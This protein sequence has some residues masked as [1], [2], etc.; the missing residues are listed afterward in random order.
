MMKLASIFQ[1]HAVLQRNV[2]IP[3]WGDAEPGHNIKAELA[4]VTAYTKVNG[5]GSFLL[6]FPVMSAGGPYT[7]TVTDMDN[8][9]QVVL[10]DILIGEVWIA[11]G[12]SNMDYSLDTDWACGAHKDQVKLGRIQSDEYKQR[13]GSRTQIRAIII[14]RRVTGI[15]EDSFPVEGLSQWTV[16]TPETAGPVS[17]VAAWFALTLNDEQDIPVGVICSSWGGTIVE[18]WTSRGGLLRNPETAF[19]VRRYDDVCK[20]EDLHLPQTAE[21]MPYPADPGNTGFDQGWAAIDFD[22]ASWKTM[23]IPCSWIQQGIAKNGSIWVRKEITLPD[24]WAGKDLVYHSGPVDKHDVTYFNGVEIGRTGKDLEEHY[25]DTERCYAIPGD[26]VKAGKNVIAVRAFSYAYD[27]N[28]SGKAEMFRIE[29]ADGN[30]V[31]IPTDGEWKATAEHDLGITETVP[32]ATVGAGCVNGPAA[33]F[34]SMIHPLIPYGIGG[35]IWYQGESNTHKIRRSVRY[36]NMLA[37]MIEDWRFRFEQGDFPFIQVELANF[38]ERSLYDAKSAWAPLREQQQSVCRRLKNVY[39]ATAIDVGDANDIHPQDKKSVGCRLAA[40]AL[41]SVFRKE[42]VAG[43]PQY[44]SFQL[45]PGG[46]RIFFRNEGK[47]VLKE[48]A[49]RCFYVANDTKREFIPADSVEVDGNSIFVRA[50]AAG[51]FPSAVRYGWSD[52]P[53]CVLYNDAGLPASPFRT[54]CWQL[55]D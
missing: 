28:L 31:A 44:E 19:E 40:H 41:K 17:A 1:S 7:L 43:G 54:D 11:S 22:D 48:N 25:W 14:P 16:V 52:N 34:D 46:V 21:Y 18:T 37:N 29:R 45:E 10:E 30:G 36:G 51:N 42:R 9:D 33:L 20:F 5:T 27:G 38:R 49:A 23:K 50:S 2:T 6:R 26:L 12:Q 39:M 53:E 24:D 32:G 3:V 8:G 47:L 13:L 35:V 4:D 55:T 15:P